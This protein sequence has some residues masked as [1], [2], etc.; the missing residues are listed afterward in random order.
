[1]I[2]FY[3]LSLISHPTCI[4]STPCV[5]L[6]M[7]LIEGWNC[8]N[9]YCPKSERNNVLFLPATATAIRSHNAK[10]LYRKERRRSSIVA[11]SVP[12]TFNSEYTLMQYH[13]T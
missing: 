13:L 2:F 10:T 7:S 6:E 11:T 8:E 4:V 1:M 5:K 12:A 3:L 9:N